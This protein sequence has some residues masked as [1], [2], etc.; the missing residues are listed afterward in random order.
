MSVQTKVEN[1]LNYITGSGGGWPLFA[2]RSRASTSH[3]YSDHR[4]APEP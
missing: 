2:V 4:R 1:Y 3:A